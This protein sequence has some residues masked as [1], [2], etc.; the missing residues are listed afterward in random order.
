MNHP[1]SS[2]ANPAIYLPP[3]ITLSGLRK[4]GK[5]WS[6]AALQRRLPRFEF[7]DCSAVAR[8]IAL[9]R[10]Y[11]PDRFGE[12]V[13]R[14]SEEPGYYP[15]YD[16]EIER[17]ALA[18]MLERQPLVIAGR[19]QHY[20]AR[21][22]PELKGLTFTVCLDASREERERR[23]VAGGEEPGSA[24]DDGD[25][26]RYREKIDTRL[27]L[28]AEV[29]DGPHDVHLR[30]STQAYDPDEVAEIIIG[31]AALWHQGERYTPIWG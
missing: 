5:N 18:L 17:R 8:A 16:D 27:V 15:D 7:A 14:V 21:V 2:T 19:V 30:V 3:L 26:G 4:S 11:G 20:V 25:L 31:S 6:M 29:G 24:R 10:G 23:A 9:E 28:P 1:P 13:R 12:F 22:H